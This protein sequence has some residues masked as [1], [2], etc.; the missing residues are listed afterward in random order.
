MKSYADIDLSELCEAQTKM[1][2][3]THNSGLANHF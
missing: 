2:Q 3:D 1:C